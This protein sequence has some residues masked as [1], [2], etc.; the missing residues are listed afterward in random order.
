MRYAGILLSIIWLNVLFA[1]E[2][3]H[4]FFIRNYNQ[5]LSLAFDSVQVSKVFTSE[6]GNIILHSD[7]EKYSYLFQ[8]QEYD[9]DLDLYLLPFR[10]YSPSQISFLQ[11]DAK[12][13]Y[14]SPYSF[15][16]GDPI[17]FV[18]RDGN[19]GRPLFIYADEHGSPNRMS[20]ATESLQSEFPDAHFVPMSD[21]INGDVVALPEW[22]GNVFIESHTGDLPGSEILAESGKDPSEFL[23]EDLIEDFDAKTGITRVG[24]SGDYLGGRL[25]E[26]AAE[27]NVNIKNVFVGGCEGTTAAE[28]MSEGFAAK[29]SGAPKG[30]RARF[31]GSK[32]GKL[33]LYEGK[34][35]EYKPGLRPLRPENRIHFVPTDKNIQPKT[36]TGENGE[37]LLDHFQHTN[38]ESGEVRDIPF[39]DR[40]GIHDIT[41]GRLPSSNVAGELNVFEHVY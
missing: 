21:V 24:V 17:N 22:N 34:G 19:E 9:S 13:Q 37:E 8:S 31:M 28:K 3:E 16:G 23:T 33:L 36:V 11:P 14:F 38:A 30:L 41:Q 1:Q 4:T 35:A 39:L 27:R 26:L 5:S 12:S 15:V 18:D 32:K 29:Q 25:Q 2:S 7:L 20:A 6:Y 10:F 40:E